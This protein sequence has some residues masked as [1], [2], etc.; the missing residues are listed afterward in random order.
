M[1][2]IQKCRFYYR[3]CTLPENEDHVFVKSRVVTRELKDMDQE[4]ID[5]LVCEN[6]KKTGPYCTDPV[7]DYLTAWKRPWG[8]T[9][10]PGHCPTCEKKGLYQGEHKTIPHHSAELL[11]L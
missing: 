11:R 4:I 5:K 6:L 9:K 8:S 1:C 2:V 7:C 3:G 10:L